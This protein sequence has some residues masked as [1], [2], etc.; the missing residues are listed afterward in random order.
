MALDIAGGAASAAGFGADARGLTKPT[1]AKLICK[2][3]NEPKD[4]A[5][6]TC[7]FNPT[8]YSLSQESG[9]ARSASPTKPG[10]V[11]Q[12]TGTRAM[13]L[14]MQLF[15]DDFASAKGDVTPQISTLMGW[16]VATEKSIAKD[17]PLPEPPMVGFEW[18]NKQL[19]GFFGYIRT[20]KVNYTVFRMD[21]TPVQAK[22]DIT[23]EG[24]VDPKTGTNPTSRAIDSHRVRTLVDGESLQSLAFRELGDATAWRAIAE[25]NGIDDPLRVPAGASLLM[26]TTANVAKR[27]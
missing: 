17:P 7:M 25:A 12:F 22:V 26:P 1:K 3:G 19:K 15:F 8:E 9:V 13:T 6:L 20:L 10:G 11:P 23:I 4:Y 14:T 21:G 16:M 18:G 2:S 24:N 27:G 5:P